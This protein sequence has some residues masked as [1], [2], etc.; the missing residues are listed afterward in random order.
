MD[1]TGYFDE[2]G[3]N[4]K[5]LIMGGFVSTTEKWDQFSKEC[6]LIKTYFNI[7]YIHATE[8]FNLKKNK[9]YGHLSPNRRGEVAGALMGAII[10]Y[11]ELSIVVSIIPREYNLLATQQ[12]RTK[13][14]SAYSTCITGIILGLIEH[15]NLSADTNNTLTFS[16]YLE[17]G[18]AHAAEAE[19][20]IR[21]YKIFTDDLESMNTKVIKTSP[22]IGLKIGEYGRLAKETASPLWAADLISYCTYNE[23]VR[24]DAFCANIMRKIDNRVPGFGVLLGREQIQQIID[25]TKLG[26]DINDQWYKDMHGLVKYLYQFGI[27]AHHDPTGI[28]FDFTKM[29]SEQKE[30]FQSDGSKKLEENAL[31]KKETR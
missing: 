4:D 11:A 10:N 6:D 28:A 29:N 30:A 9:R 18:H 26:E 25:S 31:R 14:G 2:S 12:W 8:L 15:F 21:R 20:E 16:M 5:L 7:P 17:D 13:Y 19:E 1:L 24:R 22:D 3:H 23:I 27:T